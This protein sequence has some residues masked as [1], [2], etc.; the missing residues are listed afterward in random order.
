[1]SSTYTQ[2]FLVELLRGV[3]DFSSDTFKLA[4][5]DGSVPMDSATTVYSATGEVTAGNGYTA[6]GTAMTITAT[7]PKFEGG[8]AVR[9][10]DVSWTFAANKT[11]RYA[12]IYNSSKANRAVLII[13]MGTGLYRSTFT[14]SFP[15]SV[16]PTVFIAGAL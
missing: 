2:S 11:V 15:L 8:G 13:D 14:V 5:F 7:Y 9:F 12:L 16:T 6:G 10:G 4:L 3:H 1:V